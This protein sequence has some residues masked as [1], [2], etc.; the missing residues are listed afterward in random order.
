MGRREETSGKFMY[1]DFP[2][3]LSTFLSFLDTE[4]H[5]RFRCLPE[6]VVGPQII[7][8]IDSPFLVVEINVSS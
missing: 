2:V 5:G 4:G 6:S 7:K 8:C 1:G 3:V